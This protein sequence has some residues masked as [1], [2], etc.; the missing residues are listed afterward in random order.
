MIRISDWCCAFILLIIGGV[1]SSYIPIR[2]SV[3]DVANGII[4]PK[5]TVCFVIEDD[6]YFGSYSRLAAAVDL[7]IEHANSF[8][9]PNS[10]QLQV[11]FQSSGTSCTRTLYSA[12]NAIL[13]MMEKGTTCD[14]YLGT[15]K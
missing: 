5:L 1:I 12:V 6:S 10:T 8:V 7:G 14:M 2:R 15:S 3:Q 4:P 13:D 11:V 9:M